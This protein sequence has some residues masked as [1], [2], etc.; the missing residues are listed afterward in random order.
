M[1]RKVEGLI[2]ICA[3]NQSVINLAKNLVAHERSKNIETKYHL[4][5]KKMNKKKL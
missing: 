3:D 4:L 5:R 1:H 2:K